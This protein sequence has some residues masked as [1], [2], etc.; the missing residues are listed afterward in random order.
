MTEQIVL[1]EEAVA[2]YIERATLSN[3]VD[4]RKF[5]ML[6]FQLADEIRS[7]KWRTCDRMMQQL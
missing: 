3:E 2:R 5:Q 1:F 4:D 7:G 6:L